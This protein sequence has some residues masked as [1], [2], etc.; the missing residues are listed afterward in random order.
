MGLYIEIYI[1]KLGE[2]RESLYE[3]ILS[4]AVQGCTEGATTN[5]M[6]LEQC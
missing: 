6:P 4:Q 1:E 3:I 5:G 2:F